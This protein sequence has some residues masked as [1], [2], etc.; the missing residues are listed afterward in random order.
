MSLNDTD[1]DTSVVPGGVTS[2][3]NKSFSPPVA[4]PT[5]PILAPPTVPPLPTNRLQVRRARDA[6]LAEE[7]VVRRR[8]LDETCDN[9]D[10]P[11]QRLVAGVAYRVSHVRCQMLGGI[12]GRWNYS[13][14]SC[15][16]FMN[17]MSN[18]ICD[19]CHF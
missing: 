2:C 9:L 17:H 8:D 15:V 5:M 10:T 1:I 12:S 16:R 3:S 13:Y 7:E 6:I 19:M 11:T 14:V 18:C 4:P